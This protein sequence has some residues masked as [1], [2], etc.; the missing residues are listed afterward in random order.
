MTIIIRLIYQASRLILLIFKP[1]THGVRL[2]LLRE[3]Q[4]L[5]VKHVYENK[6]YLPGGLVEKGET[7]EAAARREAWEEVG[8]EIKDLQLFG[9]YTNLENG[10]TDHITVF[11]S[12]N[13]IYNGKSDHEIESVSFFP[14][15]AL[16]ANVS[17]GSRNR[18]EEVNAG[19]CQG[20]GN[21]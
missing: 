14:L 13:F 20:H 8:A 11:V 9:I 1:M 19:E 2:L 17:T 7:L 16:P 10:Y 18:I 3:K 6:W 4:V 5:L 15:L 12:R 21:W